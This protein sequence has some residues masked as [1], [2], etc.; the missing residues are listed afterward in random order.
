MR[1]PSDDDSIR[2][3]NT[4]RISTE[5]DPLINHRQRVRPS[6]YSMLSEA[7]TAEAAEAFIQQ[8]PPQPFA[9]QQPTTDYESLEDATTH[10]EGTGTTRSSA[11]PYMEQR[12]PRPPSPS[13]SQSCGSLS[14]PPILEI[15]EEVYAVRKAALQVMKPLTKTWVGQI[16]RK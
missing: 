9:H 6:S 5:R 13:E 10:S 2:Q 14:Q 15:P 3:R 4:R 12:Q 16:S 11:K 1:I 8:Y 7:G